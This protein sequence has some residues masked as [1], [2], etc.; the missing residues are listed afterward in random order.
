METNKQTNTKV[1]VSDI[2]D[3]QIMEY[4]RYTITDRAIPSVEDGL[5]PVQRKAIWAMKQLGITHDKL[6]KKSVIPV[7]ETMKYSPHGDSGIYGAMVNM[8]SPD[9]SNYQLINGKG[10]FGTIKSEGIDFAHMRYTEV[11]LSEIAEE[12]YRET[13][14]HTT[15]MVLNYDETL[16]E[17]ETM[18]STIPLI[19]LNYSTGIG[20]GISSEI[21]PFNMGDVFR[22]VVN[23]LRGKKNDPMYPDFNTGGKIFATPENLKSI[24]KTG[25]GKFTLRGECEYIEDKHEI[26]ISVIPYNTTYEAIQDKILKDHNDDKKKYFQDVKNVEINTGTGFN[27]I[28][29]ELK[30]GADPEI[31]IAQLYNRTKLQNTFDCNFTVLYQGKPY[32]LGTDDILKAWIANRRGTIRKGKAHELDIVQDQI[33][34]LEGLL[35]IEDNIDTAIDIIQ[36]AKTTKKAIANLSNE[37]QLSDEQ[38]KYIADMKLINLNIEYIAK[39]EKEL[40]SY[41]KT[42]KEIQDI[43]KSKKKVDSLIIKD[44]SRVYNKYA[45]ER[46]TQIMDSDTFYELKSKIKEIKGELELDM[47][48]YVVFITKDNYVKKM[49][50][51]SLKGGNPIK[52]KKGDEIIAEYRVIGESSLY[53]LTVEG[54]SYKIPLTDLETQKPSDMPNYLPQ[55]FEGRMGY[56]EHILYA[57]PVDPEDKELNDLV[58]TTIYENG[59]VNRQYLSGILTATKYSNMKDIFDYPIYEHQKSMPIKVILQR[60]EDTEEPLYVKCHAIDDE[61]FEKIVVRDINEY[62]VRKAKTSKA[63]SLIN[64]KTM[65]TDITLEMDNISQKDIDVYYGERNKRVFGIDKK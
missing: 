4:G 50:A 45:K 13:N 57:F 33:A 39:K 61:D 59:F 51:T 8:A 43:L 9:Y 24:Q 46:Q 38:A 28:R 58:L 18:V 27:G 37:F 2:M 6:R 15:N 55:V 60:P 7:G 56:D 49:L 54:N 31:T 41:R 52:T 29:I 48:N 10:N 23:I 47:A 12:L 25:V 3:K 53:L 62:P 14:K 1:T 22:S 35:I 65:G 26:H 20:L 21:C 64:T 63:L 19:L 17:P 44:L 40:A 11:K 32:L 34:M 30:R 42:E 5:K 16:Y 36:N